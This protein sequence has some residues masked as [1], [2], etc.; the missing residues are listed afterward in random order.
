MKANTNQRECSYTYVCRGR[1]EKGICKA[2]GIGSKT[3]DNLVMEG[4]RQALESE[5]DA[6]SRAIEAEITSTPPVPDRSAIRDRDLKEARS[7]V[8]D[9]F[10]SQIIDK[11]ELT[12]RLAII[13]AQLKEG[14]RKEDRA[15]L[16]Q[17]E[18]ESLLDGWEDEWRTCTDAEKRA[19]VLTLCSGIIINRD[20]T[21]FVEL[22][23]KTNLAPGIISNRERSLER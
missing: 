17:F 9:L 16:S 3:I 5:R 14:P 6:I 23:I 1:K 10:T 8:I 18:I 7:R 4:L 13:D 20:A 2:R 22:I 11:Q 15:H 21:G 12:E 19:L